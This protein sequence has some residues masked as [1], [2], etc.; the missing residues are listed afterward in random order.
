MKK[1]ILFIALTGLMLSAC[2]PDGGE[3]MRAA[4]VVDGDVITLRSKVSGRL[5]KLNAEEGGTVSSG[6]VLARIDARG[7]RNRIEAERIRRREIKVQRQRLQRRRVQLAATRDYAVRTSRR[8][9]RLRQKAAVS[10]DQFEQAR[11]KRI[12]AETALSDNGRQLAALDVQA[13]ASRNREDSLRLVLEDHNLAAPV[14][15]VVLEIHAIRGEN[16]FP[17]N[18]VLEI[19]DTRSL[20]VEVFLEEAELGRLK[21]NQP[22]RIHVDGRQQPVAGHIAFFGRR[23]EFSPKYI[24]SEKERRNLLVQVKVRIPAAAADAVKLGMPVTVEFPR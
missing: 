16:L 7:V 6:R 12:A 2:S 13:D 10:G 17:G 3:T 8:L 20:F 24:L 14:A 22:V 23:A 1:R 9:Q 19:L 11:L 18:A 4:G 21:L 15:G 5:D